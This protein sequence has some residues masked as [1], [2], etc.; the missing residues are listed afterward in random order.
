MK[1]RIFRAFSLLIAA[2]VLLC[3]TA[4]GKKEEE[5]KTP[6]KFNTI[7]EIILAYE[8]VSDVKVSLLEVMKMPKKIDGKSW[9]VQGGTNDGTYGYFALNDGGSTGKS[10]TRIYKFNLRNW[11]VEKISGDLFLGHANDITYMPE[12]HQLIVN[13]CENPAENASI[14]DADTLEIVEDI[15]YPRKHV[16]MSYSPEREQYVFGG[17]GQNI[18]VYDKQLNHI[19]TFNEM[20]AQAQQGMTSDEKLIYFLYSSAT[21]NQ[22]GIITVH[23]WDG[24][25]IG[26]IEFPTSF[27]SENISIYGKSMILA[28]NDH[29]DEKMIIFYQLTFQEP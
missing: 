3:L 28:M 14:V 13:W 4:C 21:K 12:T 6:K 20:S 1:K 24:N 17:W 11:E 15:T 18:S 2:S 7:S 5:K 26:E 29:H 10:V 23:D 9:H 27:E 22:K 16:N 8:D 19:R 25:F